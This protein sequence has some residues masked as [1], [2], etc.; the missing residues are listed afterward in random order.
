MNAQAMDADSRLAVNTVL[1]RVSLLTLACIASAFVVGGI[2][3]RI[4]MGIS[5]VAAGPN[6]VGRTHMCHYVRVIRLGRC[7]VL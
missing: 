5:A 4:V 1:R 6:M 7:L 2:G 3:G